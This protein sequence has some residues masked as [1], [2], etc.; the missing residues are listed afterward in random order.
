MCRL[1]A[2]VAPEPTRISDVI[3]S[4]QCETFQQMGRLHDDGWGSVWVQGA[5]RRSPAGALA[6]QRDAGTAFGDVR[7][8]QAL[9]EPLSRARAFHLRLATGA[10][11]ITTQNTHP[12]VVDGI[13]LAHNGSIFPTEVLRQWLEPQFL[14]DVHGDTDSEL[15]L[16]LV[17]Q[18]AADGRPLPEAVATAIRRLR[19]AYPRASLNAIVM[20]STQMIV[21]HSSSVADVPYDHFDSCGLLPE[22]LPADHDESYYR[23][24]MLATDHG[25]AFSSTGLDHSG[26]LGLPQDSLTVVDIDTVAVRT[27]LIGELAHAA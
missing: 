4:A 17:R 16:A 1:L 12:F 21:V 26:W 15:Y 18:E 20:D 22:E 19:G 14:A 9:R 5:Q 24:G 27:H 2:Y 3:G 10:L 23:I 25:V 8:S 11:P 7:L 6:H 13:G